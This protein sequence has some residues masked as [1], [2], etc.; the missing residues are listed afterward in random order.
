MSRGISLLPSVQSHL[1]DPFLSLSST[2][3]ASCNK[4]LKYETSAG[5]RLA[6][7]RVP[8]ATCKRLGLSAAPLMIQMRRIIFTCLIHLH[9]LKGIFVICSAGHAPLSPCL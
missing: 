9:H 1:E 3:L 7:G 2:Y 6:L 8:Q 4:H 5:K